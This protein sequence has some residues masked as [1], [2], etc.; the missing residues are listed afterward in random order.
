[1]L[2]R[3]DRLLNQPMVR[4]RPLNR[5]GRQQCRREKTVALWAKAWV[6]AMIPVAAVNGA[7]A[8][9][10]ATAPTCVTT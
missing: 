4:G 10:T 5:R 7:T 3:R 1:M 9:R 6:R 2:N 8:T